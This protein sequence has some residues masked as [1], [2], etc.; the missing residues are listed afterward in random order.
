MEGRPLTSPGQGGG[1]LHRIARDMVVPV[2]ICPSHP[3]DFQSIHRYPIR[4]RQVASTTWQDQ[5]RV[6]RGELGPAPTYKM[7]LM[8]VDG[9]ERHELFSPMNCHSFSA[10]LL[11]VNRAYVAMKRQ[12]NLPNVSLTASRAIDQCRGAAR[13][14]HCRTR[15]GNRSTTDNAATSAATYTQH[16]HPTRPY[17][18]PILVLAANRKARRMPPRL[19][20]S[21]R[22]D[23]ETRRLSDG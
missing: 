14:Q 13:G 3:F 17:P 16:T 9:G 22:K 8:M 1:N 11:V 4:T 10:Q 18:C 7:W 23:W 19:M 6:S 5:L 2:V 12:Y 20:E 15:E 21:Q